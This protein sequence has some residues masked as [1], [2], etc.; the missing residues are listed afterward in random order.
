MFRQATRIPA[1]IETMEQSIISMDSGL[2]FWSSRHGIGTACRRRVNIKLEI[3]E[4]ANTTGTPPAQ[5]PGYRLAF[6]DA[7]GRGVF[8]ARSYREGETV[9]VGHIEAEVPRN[10]AHASQIAM[11]RFVLHGGLINKVNH[12]CSPNCAIKVNDARAHDFVAVRAIP[13]GAE[14]TFDYAMGNFSISTT[15]LHRVAAEQRL[16]AV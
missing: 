11:D 15:F 16:A 5:T 10:H 9:M 2:G 3:T 13:P 6:T 4:P 12:S 1:A 14:L 8:A 7:R